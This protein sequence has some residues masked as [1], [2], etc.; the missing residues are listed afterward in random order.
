M[1][2]GRGCVGPGITW[3]RPNILVRE[4]IWFSSTDNMYSEHHAYDL[5]SNLYKMTTLGT[6]QKWSSWKGGRLIKILYQVTTNQ[7]WSFLAG[8]S[9]FSISECFI[10]NKDFGVLVPF[11]KIK[12][13]LSYFWFWM[14][15]YWRGTIQL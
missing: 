6:T 12:N 2:T 11:L 9:F 3:W 5:Q 4:P 7:I 14:Y 10:R 13:V 15:I 1:K 8:F